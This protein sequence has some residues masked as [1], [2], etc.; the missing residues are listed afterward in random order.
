[1]QAAVRDAL[2]TQDHDDNTTPNTANGPHLSEQVQAAVWRG[3]RQLPL[4]RVQQQPIHAQQVTRAEAVRGNSHQLLDRGGAHLREMRK[5]AQAVHLSRRSAG[6]DDGA[7]CV[8]PA[9]RKPQLPDGQQTA[10]VNL[11]CLQELKETCSKS[12]AG[13]YTGSAG[14]CCGVVNA[15][16]EQQPTLAGQHQSNCSDKNRGSLEVKSPAQ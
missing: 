10:R 8:A 9:E 16:W 2:H 15:A 5:A 4:Q 12:S 6:A 13:I 14:R 11:Q 3:R 1:V 7:S